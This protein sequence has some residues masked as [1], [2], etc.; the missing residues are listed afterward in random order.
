[1]ITKKELLDRGFNKIDFWPFE[2]TKS[3]FD[4][5][6]NMF[7]INVNFNETD[8][9]SEINFDCYIARSSEGYGSDI[10]LPVNTPIEDI[11]HLIRILNL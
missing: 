8:E 4:D 9:I 2:Y 3:K 11:D 10:T 6:E 5:D 7:S 1:M